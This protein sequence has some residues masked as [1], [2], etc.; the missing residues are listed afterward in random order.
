VDSPY[1]HFEFGTTTVENKRPDIIPGPAL[2]VTSN[3]RGEPDVD[4]VPF[5]DLES[6][7]MVNH[8]NLAR[9]FQFDLVN[10]GFSALT[11]IADTYPGLEAAL[12]AKPDLFEGLDVF[13][14]VDLSFEF[15]IFA[16]AT[17]LTTEEY[18]TL[19]RNTADQLRQAILDDP[20][21]P[22]SLVFAVADQQTWEDLYLASLVE[23]GTLR[24]AD[25]PPPIRLTP[26]FNSV[27]ATI[28]SGLL[29]NTFGGQVIDDQGGRRATWFR[30]S[31]RCGRGTPARWRPAR[32]VTR[33]TRRRLTSA[34]HTRHVR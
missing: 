34:C 10:D 22:S 33:P 30:F 27:L 3:L 25:Q 13:D 20:D 2:V 1:V 32:S 18:I 28:T 24:P 21:A 26:E 15:F 5:G 14:L 8:L 7:V 12:E 9:G 11:F 19:Q 31:S 29:S 17:P 6:Q 4:G 23:A 16:A